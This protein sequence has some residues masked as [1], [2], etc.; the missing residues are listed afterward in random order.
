[1]VYSTR[2]GASSYWQLGFVIFH[3]LGDH[4]TR[5]D[6]SPTLDWM[7]YDNCSCVTISALRSWCY[8]VSE[9]TLGS[10]NYITVAD[11]EKNTD[12]HLNLFSC[13]FIQKEMHSSLKT[14]DIKMSQLFRLI[15]DRSFSFQGSLLSLL[16]YWQQLSLFT[17]HFQQFHNQW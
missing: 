10:L 4:S 5:L 17:K 3:S 14:M 2:L 7:W 9:S 1:M 12:T 11:V 6:F 15:C 13:F 16:I 8:H